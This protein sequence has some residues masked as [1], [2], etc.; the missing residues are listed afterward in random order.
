MTTFRVVGRSSALVFLLAGLVFAQRAD[1][2]TITGIVTDPSG[3]VVAGATVRLHNDNTGVD[4]TLTT[5]DAGAYTSPLLVLG[6][7][8]VSIEHAGFKAGVRSSLT[9][10]GGQEYRVD[11]ALQLGTVSE[12]VEVS[13][14]AQMVNTEQPDVANTG[15][16]I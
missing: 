8:T 10:V 11:M 9:L 5:N 4:T 16:G 14:E 2:A 3:T 6:T 15:S 12:K 13:A 1:R 7:Y